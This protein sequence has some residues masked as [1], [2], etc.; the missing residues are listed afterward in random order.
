MSM[1]VRKAL[2]EQHVLKQMT[3]V[4]KNATWESGISWSKENYIQ[5][6]NIKQKQ[7]QSCRNKS[8]IGILRYFICNVN[9]ILIL[10]F[11]NN[12][13]KCRF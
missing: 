7:V 2:R 10:Y 11:G 12:V 3:A 1:L 6:F 13:P 9:E 5:Y 8:V 4:C